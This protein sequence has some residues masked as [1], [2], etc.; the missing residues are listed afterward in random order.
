MT[1]HLP[2]LT[3]FEQRWLNL[4]QVLTC[5]T[6]WLGSPFLVGV[7]GSRADLREGA[8][9][10]APGQGTESMVKMIVRC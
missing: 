8:A 7:E 1:P 3:D 4:V 9:S 5:A 10:A 6:R 2:R